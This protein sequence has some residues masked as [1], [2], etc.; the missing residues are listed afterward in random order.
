MDLGLQGR[1]AIV[2][3]AS[4]GLGRACAMGLAQEGARVVISSR[5]EEPL[6][7]AAKEIRSA[8]GV[9]VLAVPGDLSSLVDIQNLIQRTVDHFGRLDIVISNSGGPP[10]GRAVD[11]NEESWERAIQMALQFFIRMSREAVPH[12]RRQSWGRI[13]NILASTVYQPIDN[14]AT[15]GVTRLG[16]VAFAKSLA[17]EVG[18]NNILVNN[19]APGFLLTDRMTDLFKTRARETNTDLDAVLQARASTI[20]L[21]RFGQPEELA[22][23]VTFLASEKNSYVTGTT[24][25]VDGGVVRSII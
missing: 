18:R 23:L 2:G 13:I 12:L 20:P 16:A 11:T 21:G 25:L 4:R 24:I 15:S 6:Q 19:V 3:G 14:L 10:E 9:E 8:T 1:V 22:N 17:D 5:R 7:A